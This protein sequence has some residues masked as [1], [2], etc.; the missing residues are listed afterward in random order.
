MS[1][2]F[3]ETAFFVSINYYKQFVKDASFRG[4]FANLND[5]N[6]LGINYKITLFMEAI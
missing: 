3:R 1:R 5:M 2:K 4:F 6:M